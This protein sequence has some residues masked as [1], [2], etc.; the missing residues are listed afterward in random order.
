MVT[1][2]GRA[3]CAD[4]LGG[5]IPTPYGLFFLPSSLILFVVLLRAVGCFGRSFTKNTRSLYRSRPVC[6]IVDEVAGSFVAIVR[7]AAA[8]WLSHSREQQRSNM[9]TARV[10]YLE[11]VVRVAFL[12]SLSLC[13]QD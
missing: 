6:L 9:E 2:V 7:A 8:S 11:A 12:P 5:S 10:T 4:R 13:A 3:L 1:T